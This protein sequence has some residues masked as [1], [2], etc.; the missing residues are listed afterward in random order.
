MSLAASLA[1]AAAAAVAPAPAPGEAGLLGLFGAACLAA[2]PDFQQS[3]AALEAGGLRPGPVLASGTQTFAS[4]DRVYVAMVDHDVRRG[5]VTADICTI[6]VLGP[7]APAFTD[8][9]T[10][11]NAAA[12]R[13]AS[14]PPAQEC[15]GETARVGT[16][17]WYWE[18]A[19]GCA[20]LQAQIAQDRVVGLMAVATATR[21]EPQTCR[22]A[23]R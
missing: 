14:T 13:L 19:E 5:A 10:G 11:L 18:S 1:L 22:E 20:G 12:R 8:I 15:I 9:E 3:P 23:I 4:A 2:L 6:G 17:L 7:G 16:C 21:Q